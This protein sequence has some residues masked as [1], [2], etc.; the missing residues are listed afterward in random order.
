[1]SILKGV[2]VSLCVLAA[3][4]GA[5]P[6]GVEFGDVVTTDIRLKKDISGNGD[7]LIIGA[8]GI[9]ID[10]GG[11][12]ISSDDGIGIGIHNP[13]GY[14]GIT[15]RNGTI[16]GFQEGIRSD[17][18]GYLEIRRV[19]VDGAS[20]FFSLHAAIHVQYAD[21]V[22]IADCKTIVTTT[23]NGAEGILLDS[24]ERVE[25]VGCEVCGGFVG[26]SLTS[27]TASDD[28]TLGS[29]DRC[30]LK[31]CFVAVLLANAEGSTVTRCKV[32]D[33]DDL[34][35]GPLAPVGI[36]VGLASIPATDIRVVDNDLDNAGLAIVVS[37][38][39]VDSDITVEGNRCRNG[40]RGILAV[41]TVDSKIEGNVCTG[42]T[43][44][45]VALN[46]CSDIDVK[47]NVCNDNDLRGI[48][49]VGSCVG[50]TI[51]ENEANDNVFD[52]IALLTGANVNN[53]I[54]D[55]QATGN[56]QFDCFHNEVSTPNVWKDNECDT[57][58]GA[59]LDAAHA[60][61]D[62]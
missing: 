19:T 1:M 17:G 24:V 42:N 33:A 45:G 9:T 25:V 62:D 34:G 6:G 22:L 15:I 46:A 13:D 21:H 20:G 49:L 56:G 7:G 37:S 40:D 60:E 36:R 35:F 47:E 16:E 57:W 54:R 18:G 26:I 27:E 12:T 52:G 50:I 44:F 48:V 10:L 59:D 55:N 58:S 39:A 8:D 53:V 30:D 29:V 51:K 28:P 43:R 5:A 32:E 38:G 41:T 31:G 4:A 11:R 3:T 2:F 14:S 23:V 61:D